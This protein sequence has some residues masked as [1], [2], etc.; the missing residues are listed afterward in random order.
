MEGVWAGHGASCRHDDRVSAYLRTCGRS[1]PAPRI[2][3]LLLDVGLF[4]PKPS[5][6]AGY[7]RRSTRG[8]R[9]TVRGCPLT[10]T[11]GRGDCH[12]LRHS[13][14]RARTAVG[15]TVT[16]TATMAGSACSVLCVR[17][18]MTLNCH[19]NCTPD[20][21]GVKPT[22]TAG[23]QGPRT[24]SGAAELRITSGFSCVAHGLKPRASLRF[25]EPL[26]V[27]WVTTYTQCRFL[28]DR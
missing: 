25:T 3:H 26:G 15:L 27:G 28:V 16:A 20:L 8:P 22:R 21:P 14:A 10:S 23:P 4:V 18:C 1:H 13:V 9:Q 7:Q 6:D 12:S 5:T 2:G 17:R 11:V 24:G 19:P